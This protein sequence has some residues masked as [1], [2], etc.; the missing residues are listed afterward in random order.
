MNNKIKSDIMLPSYNL[1]DREMAFDKNKY[2]ND[3]K[4]ENYWRLMCLIPRKE[5]QRIKAQAD[6][7]GLSCSA[8][9]SKIILKEVERLEN[10]KATED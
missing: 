5:E 3:Y 10:E 7:L 4:R 2:D 6:K 8:F 1:E 9:A